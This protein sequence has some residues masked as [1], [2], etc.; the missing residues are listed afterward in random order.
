M[1]FPDVDWGEYFNAPEVSEVKD[2]ENRIRDLAAV[3][4]KLRHRP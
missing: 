4:A 1:G 3:S 2:V